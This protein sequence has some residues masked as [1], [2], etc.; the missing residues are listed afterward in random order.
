MIPLTKQSGLYIA[1]GLVYVF[2]VIGFVFFKQDNQAQALNEQL[3]QVRELQAYP[4]HF[5]VLAV[6]DDTAVM[7]SPRSSQVSVLHALPLID[8]SLQYK[9]PDSPEMIKAQKTLAYYQSLAAD[10][11]KQ[12]AKQLNMAVATIRWQIDK[13]WF[14]QH[15]IEVEH[16]CDM[17]NQQQRL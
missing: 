12:Q 14:A 8:P 4:Y 13:G 1:I 16:L 7:T 11:V 3:S 10:T 17:H 6:E 9:S 15:G 5:R 2:L